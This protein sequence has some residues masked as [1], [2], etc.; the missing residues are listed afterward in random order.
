MTFCALQIHMFRTLNSQIHAGLKSMKC[1]WI[2][3]THLTQVRGTGRR[4]RT[5]L[6]SGEACNLNL[7]MVS[8]IRC[9]S[10]G[11]LQ[12]SVLER[13]DWRVSPLLLLL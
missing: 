1:R 13:L 4:M 7:C 8:V 12:M 3:L 6:P 10:R 5:A 11:A 9:V 2:V